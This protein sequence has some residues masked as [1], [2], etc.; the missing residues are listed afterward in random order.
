MD[1]H[2]FETFLAGAYRA[3]SGRPEGPDIA[4]VVVARVARGRRRRAMVLGSAV[5]FGAG[6]VG[7]AVAATGL[8]P[9]LTETL[10][11]TLPESAMIDPSLVVA[12]GLVLILAAAARNVLRDA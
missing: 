10:S 5:A 1:E 12:A 2:E 8:A 6:V 7:A 9:R 4:A 11:Q 3:P